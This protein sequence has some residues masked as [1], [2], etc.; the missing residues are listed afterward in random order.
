[1]KFAHFS[2]IWGKPGMT[3]ADRYG[4]LWRELQ[5]CDELDFDYGFCVE[6]HFRPDESWMSAPTL[7]TVAAGAR[8]KRIRLGAMGHIVPLH[9]PVRLVEEIAIADQML[10][11]RLEVGLVPGILPEYFRP[12]KVDYASRR[13][14]TLEFVSFLKAAY[15]GEGKFNF[16]G[17]FHQ[18][19]DVQLGV[20]PVQRPHPPMWIET[21]DPAT[22]DLC[23][24]E[25]VNAG[26]FFFFPRDVAVPRYQKYLARW[27]EAGHPRK[28]NI[29]YLALVYVDE[30]DE[31]ALKTALT[32]TGRAYRGFLPPD[33]SPAQLKAAQ[34]EMAKL[35]EARGEPGAAD[36]LR[37]LLNPE[38]L[39]KNDLILVGSPATVAKKL[40]QYAEEGFF[41][42]F[43]GEFNFGYLEEADI[44]RSIRL[45]GTEVL[46]ALRGFEPF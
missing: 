9:N 2:H 14:V 12:F 27:K 46:P 43:F 15:K 18:Y 7:Y 16:D 8:T 44:M 41:N 5:L 10:G 1:M 3:P 25:G 35:F 28:P 29:A 6:H 20:L 11:G 32:D 34:E 36:I 22:L 39:L 19:Q 30:T 40:R 13:E 26:Y 45:F 31:K 33:L 17:R 24:R 42:T 21:R 38:Y 37:N 23:A 4:Q